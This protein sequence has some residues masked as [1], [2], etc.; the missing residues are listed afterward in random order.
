MKPKCAKNAY[1]F[2]IK[3]RMDNKE[4]AE[5]SP[6]DRITQFGKMWKNLEED[7]RTKYKQMAEADKERYTEEKK[8][9]N[10]T[11][12]ELKLE[13]QKKQKRKFNRF[14]RSNL[15]Q[16]KLENPTMSKKQL[17]EHV[18]NVFN[19]MENNTKPKKRARVA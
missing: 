5:L 2:F 12:E 18:K 14:K 17:S 1:V 15:E 6:K 3:D 19:E 11:E 7:M 16:I 13:Q 10:P 8:N 9:Y 4:L